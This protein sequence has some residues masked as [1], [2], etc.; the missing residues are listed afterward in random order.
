[1]K[2]SK[3]LNYLRPFKI[4]ALFRIGDKADGGYVVPCSQ[5]KNIDCIISLGL[6]DNFSFE[7]H[8]LK[9]NRKLNIAIYDHTINYSYFFFK[10]YKSIKRIFYFKSNLFSIYNRIVILIRYFLFFKKINIIHFKN[11][12][13]DNP[14]KINEVDLSSII[15]KE[16]K[17]KILLKI[18]IEG[19][20]YKIL[21]SIKSYK[22]IIH[23]LIV[24]FHNLDKKRILFKKYI[25]SLKNFFNIVHIHGNNSAPLCLDNLPS[26]L[27]LTFVNKKIYKLNKKI[28]LKS[29]PI[30]N[31][32]FPNFNLKEDYSLNF[33]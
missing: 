23:I 1:M 9:L 20:E 28:Y 13:T 3:N 27:E 6:G 22:N 26:V 21:N 15:L 24:E 14:K 17:K 30:K 25:L 4:G 31:L 32:D 7:S 11:K 5:F 10:I 12:V 29:F 18:D 2:L 33:F 19:D 8:A 16:S